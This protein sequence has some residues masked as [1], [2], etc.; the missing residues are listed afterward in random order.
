MRVEP[1]T[2]KFIAEVEQFLKPFYED[3]KME[4]EVK[5]TQR[6]IKTVRGR[7]GRLNKKLVEV[8][9]I[10]K[11]EKHVAIV[12]DTALFLQHIAEM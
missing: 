7:G 2:R 8:K 6:V 11:K 1:N 3:R 9:K 10:V 4:M 12:K 5:V